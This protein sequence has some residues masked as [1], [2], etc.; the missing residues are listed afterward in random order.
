[1][2]EIKWIFRNGSESD[3]GSDGEVQLK[4]QHIVTPVLAKAQIKGTKKIA[5]GDR[6][7]ASV[8]G[9]KWTT[10][11]LW[12]DSILPLVIFHVDTSTKE[13][14]W[15]LP[16]SIEPKL[17]A[18]SVTARF[19]KSREIRASLAPLTLHLLE[20]TQ[21]FSRSGVLDLLPYFFSVYL[22]LGECPTHGDTPLSIEN[23][24][25]EKLVAVYGYLATLNLVLGRS[26]SLIPLTEW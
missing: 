11:N 6:D 4:F 5:W 26:V 17:D 20:W 7:F 16:V 2:T 8:S 24:F 13:I 19:Y 12:M 10:Y 22:E 23:G 3:Y 15:S 25:D 18:D 21:K 14:F 1:M 9:I